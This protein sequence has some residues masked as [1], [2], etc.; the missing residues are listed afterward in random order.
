MSELKNIRTYDPDRKDLPAES[1]LEISKT[2]QHLLMENREAELSEYLKKQSEKHLVTLIGSTFN[3][4]FSS[5]FPKIN[6][7]LILSPLL[8]FA[9]NNFSSEKIRYI[10]ACCTRFCN[11]R[12]PAEKR[13]IALASY[14]ER[15]EE[16]AANDRRREIIQKS[17]KQFFSN[18]S[19]YLT[20]AQRLE[21]ADNKETNKTLSEAEAKI[22]IEKIQKRILVGKP[23]E[24]EAKTQIQLLSLPVQKVFKLITKAKPGSYKTCLEEIMELAQDHYKTQENNED[25]SV[26]LAWF[27]WQHQNIDRIRFHYE[28]EPSDEAYRLLH[29]AQIANTLT[30]RLVDLGGYTELDAD[31][32]PEKY[33][34]RFERVESNRET[35]RNLLADIINSP[36]KSLNTS[37]VIGLRIALK[38]CGSVTSHV[39][40][41]SEKAQVALAFISKISSLLGNNPKDVQAELF[42]LGGLDHEFV[43]MGRDPD[44]DPTDY[45]TWGNNAVICDPWKGISFFARDFPVTDHRFHPYHHTLQIQIDSNVNTMKFGRDFLREKEAK[46][47]KSISSNF[48]QPESKKAQGFTESSTVVKTLATSLTTFLQSTDTPPPPDS[49]PSMTSSQLP[50]RQTPST[51]FVT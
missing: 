48:P 41:C 24:S 50:A 42:C 37:Q 16:F 32:E 47:G 46:E 23:F 51:S 2:I 26:N 8:K 6:A 35:V 18:P 38:D 25:E 31:E 9:M 34:D 3:R 27:Y 28:T 11:E 36:D 30:N 5:I 43:V 13:Q 4:N 19:K 10:L 22:L 12:F 7:E 49:S 21:L 1:N 29:I 14:V 20:Q 17:I 33:A 15:L 40:N 44:S 45:T 39:G